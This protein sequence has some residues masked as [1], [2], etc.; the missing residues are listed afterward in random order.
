LHGGRSSIYALGAPPGA[1]GWE[2]TLRDPRDHT[3]PLHTVVLHDRAISTS[4][5]YEQFFE[6]DGV[7]YSHIIDPRSGRPV[8]GMQSVWVVAP[9]ATDSDA[10]ST[11]FFVLGPERTRAFCRQYPELEVVMVQSAPDGE[12]IEVTHIAPGEA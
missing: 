9:S 6:A 2:F 4:G 5:D 8:Q 12:G 3:T 10:L 11:A 1:E 7:R